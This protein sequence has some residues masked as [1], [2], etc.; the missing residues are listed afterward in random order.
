MLSLSVDYSFTLDTPH[1]WEGFWG[2]DDLRGGGAADPDSK[3]PTLK[4]YHQL[5]W[6]KT[7]PNGQS[8][9]LVDGRSWSYLKTTEK[10]KEEDRAFGSDSI[11]VSMRQRLGR[12]L[13]L[14]VKDSMP[15]YHKFIED[16]VRETYT[17]GGMIIFPQIQ[18]SKN[19]ARG[20]YRK[21]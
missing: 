8:F 18:W 1:Y 13:L 12:E 3:S 21:I 15:D 2:K 17:I 5:L 19:Q 6:S 14:Q 7:L 4:R 9:N 11:L 10:D 20:F 16:F